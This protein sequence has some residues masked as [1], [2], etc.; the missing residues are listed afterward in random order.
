MS[1]CIY[2]I[3]NIQTGHKYVGQFKG[4]NPE[5]RFKGHIR[6]SKKSCPY[7]IHRA[8]RKYGYDSFKIETLCICN[9]NCINNLEAY[10]AE[11]YG[12]YI[13]DIPGG[14]NMVWCGG[15]SVA[16]IGIKMPENVKQALR[17]S[18]IGTTH[19]IESKSKM[20][21]ALKG[22]IQSPESI[23]K[24]ALARIGRKFTDETKL[25]ISVKAKGRIISQE[26]RDKI[27]ATLT[28]RPGHK[29]TF[30]QRKMASERMKGY[31]FS[32]EIRKKI[33]DTK[34][35]QNLKDEKKLL[36]GSSLLSEKQCNE[37]RNKR[38]EVGATRLAELYGVSRGHIYHIFGH[39][40][41]KSE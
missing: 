3:T 21:N 41:K 18:R 26:Q 13:W 30:Q 36:F 7:L 10:Y 2:L 34:K 11:I 23:K 20:S 24:G 27:S 1:G 4:S 14:Y 25:K 17:K 6:S 37:I 9:Y 29:K 35:A 22:R 5:K 19:T 39:I 32:P 15:A 8:M 38:E 31:V 28:G 12:T 40:K 16:R 33:S